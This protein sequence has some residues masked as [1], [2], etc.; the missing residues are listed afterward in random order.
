MHIPTIQHGDDGIPAP[1]AAQPIPENAMERLVAVRTPLAG[2][3]VKGVFLSII[4]L[5]IYRF[6]YRTRLRR[7]Y[8]GNTQLLGDGFEYTGTGKELFVGFL[9]ALAI[10][11]PLNIVLQLLVTFGG[12]VTGPLLAALIGVVIFPVL[13][14]IAIYRA[15]RYRLTRTRYRGIRFHQSGTGTAY[16]VESLKWLV[17]IVVT[18]GVMVPHMRRALEKY[19]INNT[20]YGNAQ[21]AFNAE[22]APQMKRWLIFWGAL[23]LIAGF[24]GIAAWLGI[25][26]A[27]LEND[28]VSAGRFAAA[29]IGISFLSIALPFFWVSFKV[30][31]FR[32]FTAGTRLGEM[33]FSSDLQAPSVVWIWVKYYLALTGTYFA[34][35][36]LGAILVAGVIG[37]V[38]GK[39]LLAFVMSAKGIALLYG[40]IIAAFIVGALLNELM[41][42]R[43]LWALTVASIG[44]HNPGALDGI[45]QQAG[46]DSMAVGEAFDSGFE[47]AG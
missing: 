23:V 25:E 32:V 41:L 29:S 18:L 44:V 4:T 31:E 10:I 11:I 2:Q 12:E 37:T 47:I 7:Y 17:I 9:I 45:I 16:M 46:S 27:E 22:V 14:Q 20:W 38:D 5:G 43:P 3:V 24:S 8:W 1:H 40:A 26:P 34:I 21:G 30:L 39:S 13:I 28:P 6:W 35:G 15:R 36:I 19:R 42:R 33:G